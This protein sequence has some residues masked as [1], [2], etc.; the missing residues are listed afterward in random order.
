MSE[1]SILPLPHRYRCG[2]CGVEIILS[3]F[4]QQQRSEMNVI[5]SLKYEE[6]NQTTDSRSS[7]LRK[8]F[9]K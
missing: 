2:S 3:E 5:T 1:V 7:F 8:S 9:T 6:G 4:I